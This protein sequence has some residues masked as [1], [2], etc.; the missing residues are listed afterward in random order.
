MGQRTVC[1]PKEIFQKNKEKL[2]ENISQTTTTTTCTYCTDSPFFWGSERND[3][4]I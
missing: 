4:V 2:I 1:S 3:V